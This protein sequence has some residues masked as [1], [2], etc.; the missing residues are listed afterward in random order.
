MHSVTGHSEVRGS[1]GRK[2]WLASLEVTSVGRSPD[3]D[4]PPLYLSARF[5][6]TGEDCGP[7]CGYV[8]DTNAWVWPHHCAPED[9]RTSPR[10]ERGGPVGDVMGLRI[11]WLL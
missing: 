3:W 4:T 7:V 6:V 11:Y 9:T 2:N 5:P 8:I 10:I 1:W